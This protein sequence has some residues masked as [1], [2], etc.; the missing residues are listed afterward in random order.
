MP[1]AQHPRQAGQQKLEQFQGHV[2]DQSL[3]AA[4]RV[5]VRQGLQQCSYS[6]LERATATKGGLGAT[7]RGAVNHTRC[8]GQRTQCCTPSAWPEV[9]PCCHE[10]C[11]VPEGNCTQLQGPIGCTH[12]STHK[13]CFTWGLTSLVRAVMY[14]MQSV[15]ADDQE[16]Y[17][18]CR[19]RGTKILG[20]CHV[21]TPQNPRH[22]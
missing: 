9:R 8:R 11:W 6:G 16:Q 19:K 10:V 17:Q 15:A 4:T 12:T 5:A 3:S 13:L 20:S 7:I 2:H 14:S 1:S 18:Q 21:G 22:T